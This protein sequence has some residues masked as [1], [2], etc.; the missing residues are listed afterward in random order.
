MKR[1]R[2][3]QKGVTCSRK[4]FLHAGLQVLTA[5]V[6]GLAWQGTAVGEVAPACD[7]AARIAA[8]ETG[9]PVNVLLAITRAE[10]G[11]AENGRLVPWPW[12]VNMEGKGA[13]FPQKAD[14]LNFAQDRFDAG[15][16]NFD[17]GCFQLNYRWHG[18]NFAD[19]GQMFE[20]IENA[21]YAADFLSRL[22]SETGD[23]SKAAASYH[24]RTPKYAD[25]YLARFNRIL[26]RLPDGLV[27]ASASPGNATPTAAIE[28]GDNRFPFLLTGR[29]PAGF[30]SLVP[31][32]NRKAR[33]MFRS[34]G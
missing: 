12:T 27:P 16:R 3:R 4:A 26:A 19:I 18:K 34:E 32:A 1:T 8:A 24:S 31:L 2:G 30:G 21:R 23:W 33:P 15:V 14:A 28:A 22:F 10:T 11:R 17:V 29:K 5:L 9:V 13:W 20:P 7:R 6:F 25:R